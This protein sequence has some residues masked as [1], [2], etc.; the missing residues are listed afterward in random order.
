MRVGSDGAR[1]VPPTVGAYVY[2]TLR[3]RILSGQYACG[4]RLDQRD[5]AA[6]LGVSQIPVRES[7]LK[8]E[9]EGF[10]RI[11]PRRGAFV[12]DL[13]VKEL[14]EIYLIRQ[15]LDE[16]A[17]R[18]AVPRLTPEAISRMET[19][20]QQMEQATQAHDVTS[21]VALNRSFHFLIADA[22]GYPLMVQIL[23]SLWDRATRYRDRYFYQPEGAREALIEHR[24]ILRLC[25]ARDADGAGAA[26]RDHFGH[27][28]EGIRAQLAKQS[29][30]AAPVHDERSP[31]IE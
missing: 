31:I 13:S 28:L 27:T 6:E 12:E 8:L 3:A 1:Q 25:K 9:A 20:V 30:A 23:A 15:T 10:V 16:T 4:T 7:L 2:A 24:E 11:T 22:A 21:L 19:L 29:A 26:M 18:M 14:E 17:T 5:L